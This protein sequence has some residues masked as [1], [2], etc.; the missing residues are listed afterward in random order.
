M[1]EQIFIYSNA[2]RF[3]HILGNKNKKDYQLK[4]IVFMQMKNW[5]NIINK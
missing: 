4:W 5:S 2:L 1:K 3:K